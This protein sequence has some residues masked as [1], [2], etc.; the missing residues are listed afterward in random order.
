[1]RK[2][3]QRLF[4]VWKRR[5]HS[6][7]FVLSFFGGNSG[8]ECK[9]GITVRDFKDLRYLQEQRLKTAEKTDEPLI[10][11]KFRKLNSEDREE[12]P[13]PIPAIVPPVVTTTTSTSSPRSN[14]G[15]GGYQGNKHRKHVSSKYSS[16]KTDK[17]YFPRNSGNSGYYQMSSRD[18]E[19]DYYHSRRF[20]S[21]SFYRKR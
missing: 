18:L 2:K 8:V 11:A 19:R 16:Y 4:Y 17:H 3:G 14:Y 9:E 12:S 21:N 6:C 5:S 15:G 20:N 13:P 1:M 7:R 10:P